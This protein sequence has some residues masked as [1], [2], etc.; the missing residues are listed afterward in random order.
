[1]NSVLRNS[2]LDRAGFWKYD[3]VIGRTKSTADLPAST[4]EQMR[5]GNLNTEE[6]DLL[7]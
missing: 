1:M 4:G 2:R 5:F 3:Q 7:N 6:I